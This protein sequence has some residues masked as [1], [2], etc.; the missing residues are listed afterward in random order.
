[1]IINERRDIFEHTV[2]PSQDTNKQKHLTC[3]ESNDNDCDIAD[4]RY[5]FEKFFCSDH[6]FDFSYNYI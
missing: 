1:M 2:E 6:M 5:D 4:N 3:N